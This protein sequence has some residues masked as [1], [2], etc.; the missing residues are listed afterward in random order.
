MVR[1]LRNA[2]FLKLGFL[3]VSTGWPDPA[4]AQLVREAAP[5]QQ[6]TTQRDNSKSTSGKKRLSQEFQLTGDASWVDT[7]I[8][9]QAGEVFGGIDPPRLLPII[10][11]L[12]VLRQPRDGESASRV[13]ERG[14]VESGDRV[15]SVGVSRARRAPSPAWLDR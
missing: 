15:G 2:F 7:G 9:V 1:F 4:P 13:S 11:K 10:G 6:T 14:D 5:A 8:D 3:L 12:P